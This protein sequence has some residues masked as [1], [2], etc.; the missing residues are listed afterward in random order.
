MS[1]KIDEKRNSRALLG[2]TVVT[3]SGKKFGEVG[4]ITF[5]TRTGELMQIILKNPTSYIDHLEIEQDKEGNWLVP[6]SSVV[7]VG[8][9]VVVA[10]ED[11]L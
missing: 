10:E 6:F 1:D 2:K 5:E 9:F 4:N 7:A 11:I 3:K 8:D